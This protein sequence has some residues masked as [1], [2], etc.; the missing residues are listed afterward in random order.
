LSNNQSKKD[1]GIG[2]S[3]LPIFLYDNKKFEEDILGFGQM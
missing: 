3:V 1:W 2:L